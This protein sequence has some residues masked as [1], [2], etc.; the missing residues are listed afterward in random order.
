MS[1]AEHKGFLEFYGNKYFYWVWVVGD[2]IGLV[3]TVI[4]SFLIHPFFLVATLAITYDLYY[5]VKEKKMTIIGI[6]V[7][8]ADLL[9]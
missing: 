3:V 4:F 1:K 8:F 6:I 2:I 7:S 5:V 9:P